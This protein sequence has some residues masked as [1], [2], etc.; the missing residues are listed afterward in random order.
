V[1]FSL[2]ES[3]EFE[4]TQTSEK[5]TRMPIAEVLRSHR[6][7]LAVGIFTQATSLVPFYLVTVF[8][9]S[10]GPETL[11]VPRQTILLALLI[12]CILDIFSVPYAS[13]VADR[14]GPRKMLIW[15]AV[16]MAAVAYPFFFLL[17][18][19]TFVSVCAAMILIVT[20]GHAVTYSAVAAYASGL[21]P[22]EVRYTGASVAYQ[23]GGVLFS[24]PAPFIAVA[25]TASIGS[26]V[27]GQLA[28]AGYIAAACLISILALSIPAAAKLRH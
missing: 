27:V 20:V 16:Y 26:Q 19:G 10:Y 2:T 23:M 1:R 13:A 14:I 18:V 3:P 5:L 21:F 17:S 6:A 8:V 9:L 22:A 24:A 25:I 12:A 15:G 4:K 11:G 28:L 7:P